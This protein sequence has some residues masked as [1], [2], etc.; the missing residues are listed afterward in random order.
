MN[1]TSS[2]LTPQININ[3]K[4]CLYFPN[5]TSLLLYG[6]ETVYNFVFCFEI[7]FLIFFYVIVYLML[8]NEKPLKKQNFLCISPRKPTTDAAFLDL[9]KVLLF[10]TYFSIP[11]SITKYK[12]SIYTL[13]HTH[14]YTTLQRY[15]LPLH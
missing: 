8:F 6:V 10:H 4:S 11:P 12:V 3:W 14:T 9:S 15:H 7:L 13:T 2:K 5:G 1:E